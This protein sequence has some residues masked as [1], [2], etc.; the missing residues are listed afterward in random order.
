MLY[1][2]FEVRGQVD[3]RI[4]NARVS[5]GEQ[6]LDLQVNS[7]EEAGCVRV[8]EEHTSGAAKTRQDLEKGLDSPERARRSWFGG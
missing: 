5:T 1:V 6:K 3:M 2:S 8:Y 7:F 4:G